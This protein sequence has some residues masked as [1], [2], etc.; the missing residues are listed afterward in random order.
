MK[1]KVFNNKEIIK[2]VYDTI[3]QKESNGIVYTG[4]LI[5]YNFIFMPVY[6]NTPLMFAAVIGVEVE[7]YKV[8]LVNYKILP[9]ERYNLMEYKGIGIE[10]LMH[11]AGHHI[12]G[13]PDINPSDYSGLEDLGKIYLNEEIRVNNIVGADEYTKLLKDVDPTTPDM[14]NGGINLILNITTDHYRKIKKLV[15]ESDNPEKYF[16]G[17]QE[18]FKILDKHHSA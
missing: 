11:E 18:N 4:E 17:Y 13:I 2:R 15:L 7:G 6:L 10:V 14:I 12:A 1:I 16:P 9:E 8:V 5:G 3:N